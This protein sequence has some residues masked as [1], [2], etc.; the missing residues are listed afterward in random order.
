MAWTAEQ[1]IHLSNVLEACVSFG[2]GSTLFAVAYFVLNTR[3]LNGLPAASVIWAKPIALRAG[4]AAMS[5]AFFALIR[6]IGFDSV[7]ELVAEGTADTVLNVKLYDLRWV[8][9]GFWIFFMASDVSLYNAFR[10]MTSHLYWFSFV[11][12]AGCGYAIMHATTPFQIVMLS[13]FGALLLIMSMLATIGNSYVAFHFLDISKWIM[14]TFFF[15]SMVTAW[16]IL[17]L[18]SPWAIHNWGVMGQVFP[19]FIFWVTQLLATIVFSATAIYSFMYRIPVSK[20][21]ADFFGD[22]DPTVPALN[23]LL[24][25]GQIATRDEIVKAFG[26][27]MTGAEASRAVSGASFPMTHAARAWAAPHVA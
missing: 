24:A 2:V 26:G 20:D 27:D 16:V 23:A 15:G 18:S 7:S 22:S 4:F 14:Y 17:L 10:D 8:A 1:W 3:T 13:C 9:T 25:Q 5:L 11:A 6:W 21:Y 19:E 12:W